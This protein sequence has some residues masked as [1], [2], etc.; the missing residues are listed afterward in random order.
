MIRNASLFRTAV[1]LFSLAASIAPSTARAS[2]QNSAA[3]AVA[4]A[5]AAAEQAAAEAVAAFEACEARFD[6]AL[7]SRDVAAADAA[8]RDL[9]AAR[10]R[11]DAA[12]PDAGAVSRY[13][14]RYDALQS[15]KNNADFARKSL[16]AALSGAEAD[17]AEGTWPS[18][19]SALRRI[20]AALGDAQ[21]LLKKD[22]LASA[23]A[24]ATKLRD[25]LG[26]WQASQASRER[27]VAEAAAIRGEIARADRLLARVAAEQDFDAADRRIS[28]ATTAIDGAEARAKALTTVPVADLRSSIAELRADAKRARDAVAANRATAGIRARVAKIVREVNALP[29]GPESQPD[30][31][32]LDAECDQVRKDLEADKRVPAAAAT[33][34]SDLLRT[35]RERIARMRGALDAETAKR[36]VADALSAAEQSVGEAGELVRAGQFDDADAA[37]KAAGDS[38]SQM[39]EALKAVPDAA[40]RNEMGRRGSLLQA[41]LERTSKAVA[42]ARASAA[43]EAALLAADAN[44]DSMSSESWPQDRARITELSQS[45]ELPPGMRAKA[46]ATLAKLGSFIAYNDAIEKRTRPIETAIDAGDFDSARKEL[47]SLRAAL[48]TPPLSAYHREFLTR[49]GGDFEARIESGEFWRKVAIAGS[50]VGVLLL[51]LVGWAMLRRQ[52]DGMAADLRTARE[53]KDQ[54]VKQLRSDRDR[55]TASDA[56]RTEAI[57]RLA[58]FDRIESSSFSSMVPGAADAS[59]EWQDA[60]I[61]VSQLAVIGEPDAARALLEAAARRR[62]IPGTPI[63]KRFLRNVGLEWDVFVPL[64][65]GIPVRLANGARAV[66]AAHAWTEIWR[67]SPPAVRDLVA[68]GADHWF[69]VAVDWLPGHEDVPA[70]YAQAEFKRDQGNADGALKLLVGEGNTAEQRIKKSPKTIAAA[71]Q[72]RVFLLAAN[73]KLDLAGVVRLQA[74]GTAPASAWP[75]VDQYAAN[76]QP[77]T[78]NAGS[79]G[80][81]SSGALIA[82]AREFLR[83]ADQ[84]LVPA[85]PGQGSPYGGAASAGY[86]QSNTAGVAPA[87]RSAGSVASL[88][89]QIDAAQFR[90]ELGGGHQQAENALQRVLQEGEPLAPGVIISLSAQSPRDARLSDGWSSLQPLMDRGELSSDDCRVV[91]DMRLNWVN[92]CIDRGNMFG[93]VDRETRMRFF[94]KAAWL[95]CRY[96]LLAGKLASSEQWVT[97]SALARMASTI[98]AVEDRIGVFGGTQRSKA[99][100]DSGWNPIRDQGSA[101]DRAIFAILVEI[102]GAES[103]DAGGKESTGV[104][105]GPGGTGGG[106]G[107]DGGPG[108]VPPPTAPKPSLSNVWLVPGTRQQSERVEGKDVPVFGSLRI[109]DPTMSTADVE[110]AYAWIDIGGGDAARAMGV[111]GF[112]LTEI[113]K[114][115]LRVVQKA[116]NELDA[117]GSPIIGFVNQLAD[118]TFDGL[119]KLANGFKVVLSRPKP[120]SLYEPMGGDSARLSLGELLC[121]PIALDRDRIFAPTPARQ[122][123]APVK[124]DVI[125]RSLL[126][127]SM[128]IAAVGVDAK[129]MPQVVGSAY[130]QYGVAGSAAPEAWLGIVRFFREQLGRGLGEVKD[131][132]VA[133][134][135]KA[136]GSGLVAAQAP[137][138]DSILDEQ[139]IR[140]LV[141]QFCCRADELRYLDAASAWQ[142]MDPSLKSAMERLVRRFDERNP[143]ILNRES[144]KKH[145]GIDLGGTPPPAAVGPSAGGAAGPVPPVL[146]KPAG[147]DPNPLRAEFEGIVRDLPH[148]E[149]GDFWPFATSREALLGTLQDMIDNL[150]GLSL[151]VSPERRAGIGALIDRIRALQGKLR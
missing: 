34:L 76:L 110:G 143:N 107:P 122:P 136:A 128:F 51:V 129:P 112:E 41:R 101:D 38:M 90:A 47:A 56:V 14:S 147:P 121:S 145:F 124:E 138:A 91:R 10:T 133:R 78:S 109:V 134:S 88:R 6:A 68:K 120:P 61:L 77:I 46:D 58:N 74:S 125:E 37:I 64:I 119:A 85:T 28:E 25:S 42:A 114:E 111:F 63:L 4:A 39:A 8:L 102:V 151:G 140:L 29:A 146:P 54:K 141:Q 1:L 27:E 130:G 65:E 104:R 9:F 48:T 117:S 33:E 26:A 72:C 131:E 71:L 52:K 62:L 96:W 118:L 22:E 17:A 19:Q 94:R 57:E 126:E 93:S 44:I 24:R 45:P 148:R 70:L 86:V 43:L 36:R 32:R 89:F 67:A 75:V 105:P 16:E 50:A 137:F 69:K 60:S 97:K 21:T 103:G 113:Y 18:V 30:M 123:P 2:Y 20:D 80:A 149:V 98:L 35:S 59:L 92:W 49:L 99:L 13:R 132:I 15:F 23:A 108:P 73:I 100:G 116:V 31:A 5:Q 53:R 11:L 66:E 83:R 55:S 127:I 3:E 144:L 150:Q 135:Q 82:D 84:A 139:F 95:T 81:R 106:P 79:S 40:W 115:P 7:A 12:K 142:R 87:P